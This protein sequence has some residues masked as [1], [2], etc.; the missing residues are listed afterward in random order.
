[1]GLFSR[2]ISKPERELDRI[3]DD[4]EIN[5]SNNYKSVAHAARERLGERTRELYSLG[6]INEERYKR[7]LRIYEQYT[8]SMKNYRH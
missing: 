2:L 5:L 8:Q 1:M 4:I 7:Y 3:I 6:L